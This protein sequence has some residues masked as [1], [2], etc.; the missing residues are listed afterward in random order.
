M[1]GGGINL[2]WG[3]GGLEQGGGLTNS[4]NRTGVH[5][6]FIH[7][8]EHGFSNLM[9]FSRTSNFLAHPYAAKVV[10]TVRTIVHNIDPVKPST[11]RLYM[12]EAWP[13]DDSVYMIPVTYN[14]G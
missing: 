7:L 5:L 14:R 10:R 8:G 9:A 3:G 12:W 11:E 13:Y 1:L 4:I 2:G 6:L